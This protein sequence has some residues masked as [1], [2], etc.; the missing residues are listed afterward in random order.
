MRRGL[1]GWLVLFY[2]ILFIYFLFFILRLGLFQLISSYAEVA[3]HLMDLRKR[4]MDVDGRV[5]TLQCNSSGWHAIPPSIMCVCVC[6]CVL[7]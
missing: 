5:V 4:N 6:V 7:K 3:A 1:V 2:F